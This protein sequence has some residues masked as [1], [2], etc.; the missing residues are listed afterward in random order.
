MYIK[1]AI[2]S[3]YTHN[4]TS[5]KPKAVK[6]ITTPSQ[7][8]TDQELG[9]PILWGFVST[10][11]ISLKTRWPILPALVWTGQ[12]CPAYVTSCPNNK[13]WNS[14]CL[15]NE[16]KMRW[17]L[18]LR[19]P[20]TNSGQTDN[21]VMVWPILRGLLWTPSVCATCVWLDPTQVAQIESIHT[22]PLYF[23]AH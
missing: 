20:E 15:L 22:N 2:R 9:W 21:N 3:L 6:A 4:C 1:S 16:N 5:Q 17:V 7:D 11:S 14:P 8:R 19:L 13:R 23:A 10:P 18:Q 12:I